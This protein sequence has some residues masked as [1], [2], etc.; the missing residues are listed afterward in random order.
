VKNPTESLPPLLTPVPWIILGMSRSAFYRLLAAGKVP[1]PI[2]LEGC[3]RVWRI[4]DL[5]RWVSSL[6]PSRRGAPLATV[7]PDGKESAA[8]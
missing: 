8:E 7:D 2:R 1:P 5:E 4:K 3:R 6:K